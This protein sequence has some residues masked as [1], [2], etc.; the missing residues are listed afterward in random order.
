MAVADFAITIA[1]FVV[2]YSLFGLG[3]NV[4]YGFTGL[5][6]FG[7]VAYFMIG[8]YVT[9]VLT[10]PAD[11]AAY[12]G[13]GGFALP[14]QLSFLPA[15]DLVGWLLG[16]AGGM[17]AAAAVSLFVGIPTLRLRE[18]YLAITALGVATILNAVVHN[19]HWLFNGPF[20]IR[21]I[22]QPLAGA[23]PISP[24]SFLVSL[25]IFGIPSLAI[26]AYGGYRLWGVLREL[27]LREAAIGTAGGLV[28]VAGLTAIAVDLGNLVF[29]AVGVA[30]LVA[31][32]IVAR[33]AFRETDAPGAVAGL[34][35]AEL[36]VGWYFV[37]PLVQEGAFVLLRNT[38]FLYDPAAGPHGGLDYDRFVLLF[39]SLL[40]VLAYYWV[41]RTVNS[42]YG[43]VLRSIREDEDVPEALGK[44]TFRYKLQSLA[45]GSALAG[46][47]GGLW[48]TNIGFIDPTQFA[49]TVTFFA[50]TAVIV[51]GTANNKGVVL[52]TVV[53]W[54]INAGTRF[55]DDVFPSK[56][57]IQLAAARLILVGVLL[58]VILYYRPEGIL[59]EQ[60]Y[61]IR[62]IG[63]GT[64]D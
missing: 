36:F 18:D 11:P 26:F 55:L 2:I 22:H 42:P 33:I 38:F 13:L 47:A 54:S 9:V 62:G 60:D 61:P 17:L 56:Y 25:A 49:A 53:F 3:L 37:V 24:V 44:D 57:A 7:H 45:F 64:D 27:S 32:G 35:A 20:G 8:A 23:F 4:K 41:E 6:D 40:L 29:T 12:R 21:D 31:G 16:L 10:M 63:G 58:I 43:R 51:G 30:L 46:A 59:G 52:G 34:L 50:F 39:G 28:I 19:E 14:Q 1:T 5:I 15:G 48:A